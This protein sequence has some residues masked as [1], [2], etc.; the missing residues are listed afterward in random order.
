MTAVPK[1]GHADERLHQ[2]AE[3]ADDQTEFHVFKSGTHITRQKIFP[4]VIELWFNGQR[5]DGFDIGDGLDHKG[6][7]GCTG[8]PYIFNLFLDDGYCPEVLHEVQGYT[9]EGNDGQRY[10]VPQHEQDKDNGEKYIQY[11]HQALTGEKAAYLA[12][13]IDTHDGI[14]DAAVF[15]IGQRQAD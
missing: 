2:S 9:A 14:T 3:G 15:I 5:L 1:N 10:V 8:T 6:V 12:Q 7:V 4:A 11:R 13:R